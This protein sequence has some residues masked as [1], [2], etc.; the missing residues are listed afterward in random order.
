MTESHVV[1]MHWRIS[2]LSFMLIRWLCGNPMRAHGSL[3]GSRGLARGDRGRLHYCTLIS[4]ANSEEAKTVSHVLCM[5]VCVRAEMV[6]PLSLS[7]F[8]NF[9]HPMPLENQRS[10]SKSHLKWKQH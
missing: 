5:C 1:L 6:S 10:E 2:C 8:Q 4:L 3:Y 9:P 7:P